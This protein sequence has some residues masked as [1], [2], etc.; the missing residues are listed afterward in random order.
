VGR[1]VTRAC[2]AVEKAG[3]ARVE[4]YQTGKFALFL[5]NDE[6]DTASR[7]LSTVTALCG[8]AANLC[9]RRDV[10]VSLCE[11]RQTV[12]LYLNYDDDAATRTASFTLSEPLPADQKFDAALYERMLLR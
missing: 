9:G 3:L 4:V 11:D 7:S 6:T 8:A 5:G 2:R 1:D 10:M 12:M